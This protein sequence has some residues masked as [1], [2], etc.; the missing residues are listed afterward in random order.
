MN[1]VTGET[2]HALLILGLC[3]GLLL[4]G[5]GDAPHT[6]VSLD[7]EYPASGTSPVV[8]QGWWQAVPFSTPIPPGGSSGPQSTVAASD[9]AAYVVLAPGWDP[10]SNALPTSFIVMQSKTGFAVH[11]NDTLHIPVDDEHFAGNCLAGS[12]LTQE[13]ADFITQLVFP[14]TFAAFRYDAA[15]CTTTPMG[16]AGP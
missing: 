1:P 7:N 10:S 14:R 5:C 3:A 2:E 11:L 12:R 9:N 16:D 6:Y 15:T 8:Y 4:S 13:Q